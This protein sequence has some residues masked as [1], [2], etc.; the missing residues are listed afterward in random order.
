MGW[1]ELRLGLDCGSIPGGRGGHRAPMR[2]GNS[3]G[4]RLFQT[5]GGRSRRSAPRRA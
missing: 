2:R 1:A 5:E 4:L 3:V